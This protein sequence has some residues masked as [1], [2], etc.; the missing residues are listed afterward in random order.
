[1]L[2]PHIHYIDIKY[3]E[4]TSSVGHHWTD[5]IIGQQDISELSYNDNV[6]H[7]RPV[8][9]Q[10]W[11]YKDVDSQQEI[12][13]PTLYHEDVEHINKMASSVVNNGNFCL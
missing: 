9:G 10:I 12:T 3:N 4:N 5:L 6:H 8:P 7:S 11:L 1:M 2:V 13:G